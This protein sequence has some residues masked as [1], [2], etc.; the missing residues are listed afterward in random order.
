MERET[1]I[2]AFLTFKQL[3][4]VIGAGVLLFILYY[5]IPTSAFVVCLLFIVA[6]TFAFLFIKIDGVPLSHVLGQSFGFFV[7]PRIFVWKKK[8]QLSS[9]RLVEKKEIKKERKE[10]TPLKIAP[11]SKL[12]QLSSKI[13]FGI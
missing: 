3:G 8:E 2:V 10:R 5:I 13:D 11:E 4:L 7:H 12:K 1:K 9:I 6:L